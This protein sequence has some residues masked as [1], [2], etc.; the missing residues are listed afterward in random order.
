MFLA[1]SYWVEADQLIREEVGIYIGW[2]ICFS[3]LPNVH[4]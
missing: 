1:L 2:A 3:L 4:Q